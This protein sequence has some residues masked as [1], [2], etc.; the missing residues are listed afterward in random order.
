[1]SPFRDAKACLE[2]TKHPNFSGIVDK[3]H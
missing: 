1:M 3:I 2:A